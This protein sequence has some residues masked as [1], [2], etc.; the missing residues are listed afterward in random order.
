VPAREEAGEVEVGEHDVAVGAEE[1]VLGLEVAVHDAGGVD[2]GE[3]GDGLCRVEARGGGAEDAVG[4]RVAERV[5]V[6]AGAV[7]DGPRQEL[8]RLG[9][10]EE[11]GQ[12]RVPRQARERGDLP[13]RA[14]V[15]V[16][17]GAALVKDL[18]GV[19]RGQVRRGRVVGDEEHGAHGAAA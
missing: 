11:G 12:V 13:P 7:G 3:R 8:V 14:A 15:G 19:A 18:E 5:E 10:P 4:E 17:P 16:A 6:A 9:A 2:L 1:H